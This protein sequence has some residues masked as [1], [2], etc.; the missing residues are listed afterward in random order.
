ML[1]NMKDYTY[2][3]GLELRAYPSFRQI[4]IVN[5]PRLKPQACENKP[6]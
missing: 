5:Y 3:I 4:R 2:H 6:G 1:K